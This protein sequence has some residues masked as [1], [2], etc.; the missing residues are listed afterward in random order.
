MLLRRLMS[1]FCPLLLCAAAC[2][3]FRWMDDWMGANDYW[4]FVLKG[5]VLGVA[6]ALVLPCGGVHAHTNGLTGWLLMGAL[7][8][9]AAIV[10]Q[11]LETTG[12]VHWP[13]LA[14]LM[15]VNGQVVLVESTVMGYMTML[16]LWYR[17]R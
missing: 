12:A 1:A 6:L 4:S 17:R 16:S 8:L 5:C 9:L 15:E 10:Y 11:Y 14:S 2:G 3:F 13:V 7:L